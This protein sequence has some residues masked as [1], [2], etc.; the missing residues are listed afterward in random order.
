VQCGVHSL[1]N[2][3]VFCRR[4]PFVRFPVPDLGEDVAYVTGH[5]LADHVAVSCIGNEG[6]LKEVFLE[7]VILLELGRKELCDDGAGILHVQVF[8]GRDGPEHGGV[9]S[10]VARKEYLRAYLKRQG[11]PRK[12]PHAWGGASQLPVISRI[13]D[14]LEMRIHETVDAPQG[15]AFF[16]LSGLQ[17]PGLGQG[18][19]GRRF[20]HELGHQLDFRHLSRP[21]PNESWPRAA[22]RPATPRIASRGRAR[23][24]TAKRKSHWAGRSGIISA[25]NWTFT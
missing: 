12:F 14:K 5:L 17:G 16:L 11:S 25:G 10:V 6:A 21:I 3:S 18:F 13:V 8:M 23:A 9:L 19:V 24:T 1:A 4:V 2:G 15:L 20:L 22:C 7:R